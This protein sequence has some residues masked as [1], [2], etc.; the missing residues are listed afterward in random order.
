MRFALGNDFLPEYTYEDYLVWEGNWELIQG[1][2]YA[3][4]PGPSIRHQA[5]NSKIIAQLTSLLE[6]CDDCQAYMPV[7]WKISD[8]TVVQPDVSILCKESGNPNYLDFAPTV[9]FEILS[10][11]TAKKDRG[12]KYS[13]YE[14]HGVKYYVI[15]SPDDSEVEV[16]L[17]NGKKYEQKFKGGSGEF[18]FDLDGCTVNF[19]FRRIWQ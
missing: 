9:I 10:K 5:I 12:L 6:G 8:T 18:L 14:E 19:D 16:F 3:M 15:V 17:L 13:L 4:S 2:P 7:D 1:V 11:A